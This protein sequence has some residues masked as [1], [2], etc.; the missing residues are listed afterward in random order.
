[1]RPRSL[2]VVAAAL[3]LALLA[4]AALA[5]RALSHPFHPGADVADTSAPGL[6]LQRVGT[7]AFPVYVTSPPGDTA[8]QF[9]VEQSGQIRI[10]K[11]GR[12]VG[13]PFLDISGRVEFNGS[14]RGLL[15]MAFAPDY[16]TSGRFYVFYTE[17]GGDLRVEEFRRS[18]ADPD[19]AVRSSRRGVLEIEH[20]AYGNHNGGQLQYGPGGLYVSTGDGGGA[21]DPLR[22]GQNLNSLLGKILRIDPRR[23][24]STRGYSVPSGNPFVGR[25]GRDEIWHYGLRNP[26]RFSFD[27]A[28]GNMSIGD[29][30]QGAME[31]VDF[32]IKGRRGANFGWNCFEGTLRY[33]SCS[34]PGHRPPVLQYSHEGGASC[35][36]TGG[37]VLRDRTVPRLY[38]RYLYGDYCTG[39]LHAATLREAG[40]TTNASLSLIVPRLTSFGE[41]ARGRLYMTSRSYG[42]RPGAVYRLR[43]AP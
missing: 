1:L 39:A 32:V 6:A 43:A 42:G 13:R 18:P 16:A 3:A 8:R 24:T 34:A 40:A 15:S 23:P 14:E 19:V 10:I 27:R 2:G 21:G 36:V 28:N 35:S 33:S 29:V 17:R 20:S 22:N 41:D 7:F 37:Y 38:G 30:G 4:V 31:E 25:F 11:D 26:W 5:P 12:T 9:V